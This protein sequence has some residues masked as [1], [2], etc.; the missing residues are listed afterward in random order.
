MY[1]I[2]VGEFNWK[3]PLGRPGCKWEDNIRMNI[4]EI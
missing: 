4:K 1:K 3:T 2:S